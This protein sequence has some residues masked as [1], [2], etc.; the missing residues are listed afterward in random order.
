M[1]SPV[2]TQKLDSMIPLGPFQ[3]GLLYNSMIILVLKE[4]KFINLG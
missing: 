4:K 1:N 3:L 2:W